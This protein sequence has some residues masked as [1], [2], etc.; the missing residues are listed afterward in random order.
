MIPNANVRK[1][2]R[3]YT[4]NPFVKSILV[5]LVVTACKRLS[6]KNLAGVKHD[7]VGK[8]IALLV[9]LFTDFFFFSWKHTPIK[10]NVGTQT[11]RL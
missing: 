5:L 2:K 9:Y 6:K 10:E 8:S 3:W 7:R 11:T 1:R 4:D